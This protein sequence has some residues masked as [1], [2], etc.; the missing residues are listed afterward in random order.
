MAFGSSTPI[1]V[2][3]PLAG[4]SDEIRKA[5]NRLVNSWIHQA[6]FSSSAEMLECIGVQ[7]RCVDAGR[8]FALSCCVH[9]LI[10][11]V[12]LYQLV[13]IHLGTKKKIRRVRRLA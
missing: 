13:S 7:G 5:R 3:Y 8:H 4:R 11:F 9:F 10:W 2:K 1:G 6:I 12:V